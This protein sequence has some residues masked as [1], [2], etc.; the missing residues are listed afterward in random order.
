MAIFF[1]VVRIGLGNVKVHRTSINQIKKL[2]KEFKKHV[3]KSI[4]LSLNTTAG[5]AIM[6]GIL[7]KTKC[8]AYQSAHDG[9]R[10]RKSIQCIFLL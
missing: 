6:W 5:I 9:K 3:K 1:I 2:L 7:L 10:K 4:K 8:F